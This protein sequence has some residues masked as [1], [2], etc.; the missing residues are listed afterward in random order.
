M[1]ALWIFAAGCWTASAPKLPLIE[2]PP[3]AKPPPDAKVINA[4]A[5]EL[6]TSDEWLGD[7]E[8]DDAPP[9]TA[10]QTG[11]RGH[12]FQLEVVVD[13][14]RYVM[15]LA[16]GV[17]TA[18]TQVARTHDVLPGGAKE[19][20]FEVEHITGGG[21]QISIVACGIGLSRIP[22]CGSHV[23]ELSF[24]LGEQVDV[25][26]P[27]EGGIHVRYAGDLSKLWFTFP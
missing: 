22:S 15:P 14:K 26:T 1:R 13:R 20:V 10:I 25:R 11:W 27:R 17:D 18:R 24:A 2:A 3:A 7:T 8:L 9:W 19:L 6:S 5:L 4:T 23:L 21:K 16:S 12:R